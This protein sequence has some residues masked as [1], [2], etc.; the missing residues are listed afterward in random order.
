MSIQ[1]GKE[2]NI[3]WEYSLDDLIR[4]FIKDD[5]SEVNQMQGRLST[6]DRGHLALEDLSLTPLATAYSNSQVESP[7]IRKLK[8]QPEVEA[9]RLFAKAASRRLGQ[10]V[11]IV[12][13]NRLDLLT[14]GETKAEIV[15]KELEGLSTERTMLNNF[16]EKIAAVKSPGSS[17]G[18]APG[19]TL[20]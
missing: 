1:E 13:L 19:Q 9:R 8:E 6:L 20:V 12:S 17:A 2:R 15:R 10:V 16:L 3:D 4:P 18:E 7:T 14:F 11:E 5:P